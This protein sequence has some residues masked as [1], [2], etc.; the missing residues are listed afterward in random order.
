MSVCLLKVIT[1]KLQFKIVKFGGCFTPAPTPAPW[2]PIRCSVYIRRG[3]SW[4]MVISFLCPRQEWNQ[5]ISGVL[6]SV[7]VAQSSLAHDGAGDTRSRSR[8]K[9]SPVDELHQTSTPT[10]W[11]EKNLIP[12]I[13]LDLERGRLVV[14]KWIALL[15]CSPSLGI[16]YKKV[17]RKKVTSH[18]VLVKGPSLYEGSFIQNGVFQNIFLF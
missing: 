10:M 16:N 17:K 8:E 6:L 2:V 5:D 3:W 12:V 14:Y 18:Q 11:S 9:L 7:S 1:L 13:N 15:V 4:T